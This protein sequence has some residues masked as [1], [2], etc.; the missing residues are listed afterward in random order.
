MAH[1][2]LYAKSKKA[3]YMNQKRL[4]HVDPDAPYLQGAELVMIADCAPDEA[5]ETSEGAEHGMVVVGCPLVDDYTKD[6][7]RLVDILWSSGLKGL[8]VV[9][10]RDTCCS[11]FSRRVREAVAASGNDIP[12]RHVVVDDDGEVLSTRQSLGIGAAL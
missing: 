12:L 6:M 2:L 5:N 1:R 3:V 8:T 11:S 7:D 9:T 10:K 4:K